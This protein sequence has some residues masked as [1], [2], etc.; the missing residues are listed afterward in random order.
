M[1]TPLN[2]AEP[3]IM[4]VDLNACFAMTE[5]QANPLLRGRAVA[6]TN[7]GDTGWA[8]IVA[9]SYEAKRAGIKVGTR[10]N[11]AKLKS[12]GLIV[13]ETDPPKY[14]YVHGVIK[15]I[16]E[17]V[18]PSVTMKSIDEGVLDFRGTGQIRVQTLEEIGREIK[19][20]V[21]EELG[22]WMTV[23]V[24]ISTNRFLAKTAASLNKP[25]GLE[26]ITPQNLE[27]VYMSMRIDDL[28]GINRRFKLRLALCGIHTPLEF[29]NASEA[30]L[31][32][33]VFKSIHG[34]HWYYRLRGYEV[35]DFQTTMRQA[36]KQYVLEH[37]TADRKQLLAELYRLCYFVN[38]RLSKY[39]QAAG[40]LYVALRTTEG[41]KLQTSVNLGEPIY[42]VIDIQRVAKQLLDRLPI[43]AT[44]SRLDVVA[45]KLRATRASQQS[46]YE[47]SVQTDSRVEAA[48]RGVNQKFG[49]FSLIPANLMGNIGYV[50]EKIPFGSTRYI[51]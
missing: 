32:K 37:K 48:I 38:S 5:Q 3:E 29:L 23:N 13:L 17:D 45:S 16:F 34:R 51:G 24:G 7:R 27:G 4:H 6:V 26:T 28:T 46:L 22:D 25:N 47:T 10:V 33:Q 31:S 30:I 49:D 8:T 43:N 50:G 41:E 40:S 15:R 11:D 18:C 14:H 21:A 20:R 19:R 39:D 9:P 35:D 42:R 36:G 2:P 44:V 1:E 12:P